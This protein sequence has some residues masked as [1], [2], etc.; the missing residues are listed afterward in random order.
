VENP[1]RIGGDGSGRIGD[2]ADASDGGCS[3]TSNPSTKQYTPQL[4]HSRQ[5]LVAD[6]ARP[7]CPR[8][9]AQL[10]L[11]PAHRTPRAPYSADEESSAAPGKV[12]PTPR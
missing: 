1:E 8:R 7:T 6:V 12:F 10:L 3:A 4:S 9:P 2:A 11:N 5:I